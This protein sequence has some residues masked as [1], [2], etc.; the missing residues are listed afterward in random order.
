MKAGEAGRN[1]HIVERDG[2]AE[3]AFD[4]PERLANR[5]HFLPSEAMELPWNIDRE[6]A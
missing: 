4:K 2:L 3:V 1:G 6:H 5:L